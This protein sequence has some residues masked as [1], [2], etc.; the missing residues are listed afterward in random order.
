MATHRVAASLLLLVLATCGGEEAADL[1]QADDGRRLPPRRGVTFGGPL[2]NAGADLRALPGLPVRLDGRASLPGEEGLPIALRWTQEAGPRVALDDPTAAEPTFVAPPFPGGED[3]RLVFLLTV[4]DGRHTST[5]RVTVELVAAPSQLL[6]APIA[7]AGPDLAV[8]PGEE[9]ELQAPFTLDPACLDEGGAAGCE[10]APLPTAWAQVEGPPV[11][12][13]EGRFVAPD[14]PTVLTFR[15]D[16]HRRQEEERLADCAPGGAA[17]PR[18]FCSAADHVRVVVG[19][20]AVD[21]APVAQLDAPEGLGERGGLLRVGP[22]LGPGTYPGQLQVLA[23][24]HDPDQDYVIVRGFHPLLPGVPG[25]VLGKENQQI[26]LPLGSGADG[27]REALALHAALGGPWQRT[28]AVAFR[29]RAGRLRSAPVA[30]AIRWEPPEHGSI[31]PTAVARAERCLPPRCSDEGPERALLDGS[32]SLDPDT[33]AEE[34][35]WCWHQTLGPPVAFDQGAA[36]QQG[37]PD[38]T[39]LAPPPP[40]DGSPL[41]LGFALTVSDGGPL[42]SLPDTALYEVAS[43]P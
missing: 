13:H 27:G 25:G 11:T 40:A 43:E 31:P 20:G 1:P 8:R 24:Y 18:A 30:A 7:L 36:C 10:Q 41:I 26:A 34:L 38:R 28:A 29:A 12:L 17:R 39:F 21:R 37:R 9:V 42:L 33:P 5:D 6:P 14:V 4:D 16:A 2:A 19:A 32:D 22:G 23:S 15:L 35:V 3:D